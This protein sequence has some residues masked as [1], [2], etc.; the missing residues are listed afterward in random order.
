MQGVPLRIGFCVP[1]GRGRGRVFKR[2]FVKTKVHAFQATG[3]PSGRTG[4][5]IGGH[6]HSSDRRQSPKAPVGTASQSLRGS[7]SEGTVQLRHG[8]CSIRR[9]RVDSVH[10]AWLVWRGDGKAKGQPVELLADQTFSVLCKVSNYQ[11]PLYLS[12]V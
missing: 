10:G 1:M 7:H 3:A 6:K 8:R 2:H 5:E 12:I 4:I 11:Q 9:L